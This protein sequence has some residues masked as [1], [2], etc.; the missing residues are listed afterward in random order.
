[1]IKPSIEAPQITAQMRK[2]DNFKPIAQDEF[3]RAM[4]AALNVSI[5]D[6]RERAPFASGT[7][8]SSVTGDI[9][10]ASGEEVRGV[11]S[12]DAVAEDGF[13]YGYALNASKRYHY[14]GRRKQT[15]GWFSSVRFRKRKII[16]A[17]FQDATVRIVNRLEVN[18]NG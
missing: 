6:V 5:G 1:M 10:Y 13:R 16:M 17:L 4:S 12:A 9:R 2:L 7:L 8:R 11:I 18:P 14:N 15:K 3:S